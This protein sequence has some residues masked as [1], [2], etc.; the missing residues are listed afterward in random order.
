M[1][2]ILLLGL[3]VL[4]PRLY[5]FIKSH[6]A[7]KLPISVNYHLTRQCTY[8]CGAEALL[9]ILGAV[10]DPFPGFYFHTAKTSHVESI[11]NAKKAMA[12]LKAAGMKED[13]C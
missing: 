6:A 13:H 10:T 12:L 3:T 5:C 1:I 7:A 4:I 2:L 11:P 9:L 8:S